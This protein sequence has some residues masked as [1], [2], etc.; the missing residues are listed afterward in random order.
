VK[1][2]IRSIV[3]MLITVAFLGLALAIPA[4]DGPWY[5]SLAYLVCAAVTFV[6]ALK[7][8]PSGTPA[9]PTTVAPDE[10]ARRARRSGNPSLRAQAEKRDGTA[11]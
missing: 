9:R 7:V 5:L 1:A 11:G 4:L 3:L 8:R 6:V 2:W 10:V